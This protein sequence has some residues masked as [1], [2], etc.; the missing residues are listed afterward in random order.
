M[1][2]IEDDLTNTKDEL[3]RLKNDIEPH[4]LSKIV[5]EAIKNQVDI[6]AAI[7]TIINKSLQENVL[8]QGIIKNIIN[9]HVPYMTWKFIL[10]VVTAHISIYRGRT[11]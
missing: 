2:S 7:Q 4:N 3:K 1:S 5:C 10:G 8:T 9:Q 6:N 11:F